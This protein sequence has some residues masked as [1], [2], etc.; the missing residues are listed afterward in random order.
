MNNALSSSPPSAWALAAASPVRVVTEMHGDGAHV[1]ALRV[2]RGDGDLA[3]GRN[4]IDLER[5]LWRALER[6][7]LGVVYQPLVDVRTGRLEGFE[8][9]PRWSHPALGPIRPDVL[10]P[11]AEGSGLIVPIGR[12]LV[13]EACRQLSAWR[14]DVSGSKCY[15]SVDVSAGQLA[16]PGLARSVARALASHRLPADALTLE[17]TETVLMTAGSSEAR[18]IERLRSLGV[19][20]LLD[21]FG[22]GYSS[23]GYAG[24]PARSSIRALGR[25]MPAGEAGALLRSQLHR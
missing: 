19:R 13:A 17:L 6:R 9:L 10:H 16:D 8:A 23:F 21:H 3:R 25:P 22:T 12:W 1:R 15:M 20:L 18:A 2:R 5:D 4:R 7:E 14:A 11:I 24:G